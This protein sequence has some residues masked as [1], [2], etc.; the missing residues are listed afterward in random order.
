M[1]DFLI[2]MFGSERMKRWY[3]NVQLLLNKKYRKSYYK[4]KKCFRDINENKSQELYKCLSEIYFDHRNITHG[5]GRLVSDIDKKDMEDHMINRLLNFRYRT[6]PWL[7][8]L[9]SLEQSKVLEIGCGTGCTTVAL[10]EQGCQLTSIDVN[11]IHLEVAK[12]RCELY[13]LSANI[14]AMNA[15]N[16]KE[17][18][19]KFD[20]IIFSAS[21]EHMTYEERLI[22][23][24][25]AWNMLK[26][27]GFLVVI[28]TPNRLYYIDTH[29]SMLPFY[30]WL[31]DQLAMQYSK[32]SSREACIKNSFDEM[33][34]IRFGRGASFHEFEIALDIRYNAM[35]VYSMQ[36]FM[37]TVISNILLKENRYNNFLKKLGPSNIPEGF[38]YEYLFIAIKNS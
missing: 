9:I 18:N 36:P 6:I 5:G 13:N 25:S 4:V 24:K 33:K 8:S 37:G 11:N 29:S 15:V 28:E 22:S 20:L 35:E 10:A 14:F 30:H 17:I 7:N 31:P 2:K 32:F 3:H 21:L 16:I 23:I 38:Y 27:N 1:K 34:F 12:K 26:K 19:E